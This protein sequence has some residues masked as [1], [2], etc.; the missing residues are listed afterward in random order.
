MILLTKKPTRTYDIF[1]QK[2]RTECF[3]CMHA[4]MYELSYIHTYIHTCQLTLMTLAPAVCLA[5]VLPKA[6]LCTIA[7]VDDSETLEMGFT[8]QVVADEGRMTGAPPM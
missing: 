1:D 3:V 6:P 4:C 2:K 5:R 8:V 7:T